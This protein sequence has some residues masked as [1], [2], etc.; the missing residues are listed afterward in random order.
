MITAG[1]DS[2]LQLRSM[3][4]EVVVVPHW[5]KATQIETLLYET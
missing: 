1:A 4:P 3:I 5:I 2:H